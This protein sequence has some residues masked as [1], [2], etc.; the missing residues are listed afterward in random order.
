[1]KE[2]IRNFS[3]STGLPNFYGWL[4]QKRLRGRRP[5]TIL[6]IVLI[7]GSGLLIA[8]TTNAAN[9]NV[10]RNGNFES[11]FGSRDGCGMV[12]TGW[13]CFTNGGA[14][15][16]GFYDDQWNLTVAD[17]SHSQLLELNGKGVVSPDND[18][19]SGIYQTVRV[20]DWA[21]YTLN[22]SGM[23]RTTNLDGDPWRY[24]VQVGWTQGGQAN[25]G[26]VTNWTDVGWDKYY[27]RTAPGSFSNFSTQL[28]AEAK[29]VTVYVRVWR[30]WGIS[31]EELDVNFDTIS[32]MGPA[33]L[34]GGWGGSA[35]DQP[36]PQPQPPVANQSALGWQPPYGGQPAPAPGWQPPVANQP[37]PT[38]V[39]TCE[40]NNQVYNGGFEQGF[41]AVSLGHVGKSWGYFTNGGAANY[42]FYDEQ[43][44]P[45]IAEGAHGQL[46]ELNAKAVYPADNDR[47]AGIYQ[48]LK[49]LRPGATY[50]LTVKGMLRG[51]GNADDPYRFETQWGFNP[52]FD[53]EW[54]HVA[55]W[56]GMDF[57]QTYP[58]TEPGTVATYKVRFQAT[59]PAMVLFVRGWKKWGITGV[60]MDLNLDAIS[61]L[62]C[63]TDK[64]LPHDSHAAWQPFG[65]DHQQPDN[66]EPSANQC[67]YTVQPGDWLSSIANQKNISV[68]D[69]MSAN[70]LNDPNLLYVGQVLQLPGCAN[71]QQP[72]PQPAPVQP[73]VDPPASNNEPRS[74]TVQPG[75]TLS[76]IAAQFGVDSGALAQ[77]NSIDN[78]N[79]IYVGQVLQIP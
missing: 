78:P 76:V 77:A 57:G 16:Y 10:L 69:L 51:A 2:A 25:W 36:R 41:N 26:A 38:D 48:Q 1:M 33:P 46:I 40:G 72:P 45:V 34:D 39:T 74:Y 65:P 21:Q 19:Y 31:G 8:H 53:T 22:L 58:R 43:W 54:M 62:A 17:G 37:V 29:F 59:A 20:Q 71:A 79:W 63:H 42:G 64:P 6:A 12:G 13:Q 24:R 7:V 44:S 18:R 3:E 28:T 30:K 15:N 68:N 49:G 47:Y 60:E 56:Q 14:A 75:D 9:T 23:I 4:V 32:L 35:P 61:L 27:E 50:E 70:S 11:G 5:L 66:Q 73:Q 55:N 67:T 52:G